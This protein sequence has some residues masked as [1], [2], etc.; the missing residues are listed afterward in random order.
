MLLYDGVGFFFPFFDGATD[1]LS[2]PDE[3]YACHDTVK[4]RNEV[5]PNCNHA[6]G[7]I[8]AW[9]ATPIIAKVQRHPRKQ[10]EHYPTASILPARRYTR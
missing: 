4:S 10:P 7:G 3:S 9:T 5:R 1:I 2:E 6:K 8:R